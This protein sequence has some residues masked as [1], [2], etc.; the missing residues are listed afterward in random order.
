M[1][2]LAC[3]AHQRACEPPVMTHSLRYCKMSGIDHSCFDSLFSATLR[4]CICHTRSQSG[5]CLDC[6]IQ[7]LYV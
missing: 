7:Y 1:K 3:H 4:K 5:L 6:I 2:N